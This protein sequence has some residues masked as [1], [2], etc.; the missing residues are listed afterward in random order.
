MK[1]CCRLFLLLS[2][3]VIFFIFIQNRQIILQSS[4]FFTEMGTK[5]KFDPIRIENVPM[6]NAAWCH[7]KDRSNVERLLNAMAS[8]GPDNLQLISDFDFTITRQ[9]R[10]DG[11]TMPTSFCILNHCKSLPEAW[12][13]E[14]PKAV[15]KYLPIEQ[16]NTLPMPQR[17]AAVEEWSRLTSSLLT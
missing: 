10:P 15:I 7:M 4:T 1:T 12:R 8:G 13:I 9:Y 3:V 5:G 16:D 17:I 14:T 2:V 6:L 11:S